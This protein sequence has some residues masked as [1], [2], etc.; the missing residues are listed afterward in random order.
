MLAEQP[1]T[2][3]PMSQGSVQVP[4]GEAE[5]SSLHQE[6]SPDRP[7][8]E[9]KSTGDGLA[10][11][12]IKIDEAEEGVDTA[13]KVNV[14]HA[15]HQTD[16][17][18][19]EKE[20]SRAVGN[21]EKDARSGAS[22]TERE[23]SSA[24]DNGGND[25]LCDASGTEKEPAFAKTMQNEVEVPPL[26]LT[27]VQGNEEDTPPLSIK[28]TGSS[29]VSR[30]SFR[31]S[32]TGFVVQGTTKQSDQNAN[33]MNNENSTISEAD[34]PK[35]TRTNEKKAGSNTGKLG[36][37][38][39]V[40]S[41]LQS[42]ASGNGQASTKPPL[43][44]STRNA[45][46]TAKVK[47]PRGSI[48]TTHL[49][50]PRQSKESGSRNTDNKLTKS[51]SCKTPRT[52]GVTESKTPRALM[53]KKKK[54]MEMTALKKNEK[55][56]IHSAAFSSKTA[57]PESKKDE[58]KGTQDLKESSLPMTLDRSI[59]S[60]DSQPTENMN[61]TETKPK[62]SSQITAGNG[63]IHTGDEKKTQEAKTLYSCPK[64]EQTPGSKTH[65]EKKPHSLLSRA[66]IKRVASV[67]SRPDPASLS[68]PTELKSN[69][70]TNNIDRKHASAPDCSSR[71]DKTRHK[72]S[73]TVPSTALVPV[74]SE[75]DE[76]ASLG[77]RRDS[78][79][80]SVDSTSR[81][82]V[83][84]RLSTPQYGTGYGDDRTKS[85]LMHDDSIIRA[86]IPFLPVR[87]AVVCLVLNIV[88]PGAGTVVSGFSVLC[89]GSQCRLSNKRDGRVTT[90]CVNLLVGVT[91][92]ATV[93][94]LLVGWFWSL[95]WGIKMVILAG[96]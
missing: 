96:Q 8:S 75:L 74:P 9:T 82:S 94:F 52:P 33:S 59:F 78:V 71:P 22:E 20:M 57:V 37:Q 51:S 91:Q 2:P 24:K 10:T 95:A 5:S 92:L 76:R 3:G 62:P 53:E 40:Y 84:Y 64:N 80:L 45:N 6:M 73:L 66:I 27:S 55:P 86:A 38:A 14:N 7:T 89:G 32:E 39:G 23:T 29:E 65:Q 16:E 90:V 43:K 15:L 54:K 42:A 1:A 21:G 18:E 34:T 88:L 83:D 4:K 25:A 41:R 81:K 68:Q 12:H 46:T 17:T 79:R 26:D 56:E 28:T 47:T 35:D 31:E 63:V 44:D 72:Q 85:L 50:N 87:L 67:E 60:K 36:K 11:D 58:T 49:T 48:G 70:E 13:E 61:P 30:D 93:V 19:A 69:M 77:S